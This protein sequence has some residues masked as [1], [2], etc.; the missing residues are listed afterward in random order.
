VE[1]LLS[2]PRLINQTRC[3][4]TRGLGITKERRSR[5]T[6][7][8]V[9][10]PRS[11]VNPSSGVIAQEREVVRP[12]ELSE[13]GAAVIEEEEEEPEEEE[14][15]EEAEETV[16]MCS[17]TNT[18]AFTKVTLLDTTVQS[19]WAVVTTVCAGRDLTRCSSVERDVL[20]EAQVHPPHQAVAVLLVRTRA[21]VHGEAL[22]TWWDR[23]SGC[24]TAGCVCA[25]GRMV[26]Q[27]SDATLTATAR[28]GCQNPQAGARAITTANPTTLALSSTLVPVR[29]ACV[30]LGTARLLSCADLTRI[31]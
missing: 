1:A 13:R 2:T 3:A 21:H 5:L 8:G 17:G 15:E 10:V 9:N 6:A 20:V 22:S 31:V 19:G 27:W 7:G 12:A 25:A 24:L 23:S 14:I 18:G 4:T 26:V 30:Q 29:T 28:R 16:L 11:T